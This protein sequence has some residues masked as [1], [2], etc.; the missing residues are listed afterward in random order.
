MGDWNTDQPLD[1]IELLMFTMRQNLQ[2][3]RVPTSN[4]RSLRH[5]YLSR[6]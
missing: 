5:V 1:L 4:S 6:G 2:D 3:N